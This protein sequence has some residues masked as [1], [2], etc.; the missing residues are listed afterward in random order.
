M[1][2][3]RNDDGL[4]VRFGTDRARN[5]NA[6][7]W[8]VDAVGPYN[9]LIV[10]INYDN[11]PTFTADANNDGTNDAFSLGDPYIPAGAYITKATVIVETAFADGTDYDI[12]LY[13]VDGS[14]LDAVGIDEAVLLASLAANEAHVCDGANVGGT[15]TEA[16]DAYIV[17]AETGTFTAG[18]AKLVIEYIQTAP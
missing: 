3:W 12:G 10:D 11:L 17:V 16:S 18:K 14:A 9:Y 2:L 4:D 5:T 7:G 8:T 1:A 6:I 13:D 15:I